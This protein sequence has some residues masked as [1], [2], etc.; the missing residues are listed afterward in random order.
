MAFSSAAA[1]HGHGH[2]PE[3]TAGLAKHAILGELMFEDTVDFI[4]EEKLAE[5]ALSS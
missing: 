3:E 5:M 1:R 4:S 2:T